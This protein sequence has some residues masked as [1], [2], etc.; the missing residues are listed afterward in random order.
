[1][2]SEKEQILFGLKCWGNRAYKELLANDIPVIVLRGNN[3]CRV[4]PSGGIEV[5]ARVPQSK[6]RI[7]QRSIKLPK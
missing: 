3:I 4:S 5:I 6:Y 2:K 1:M 7:R